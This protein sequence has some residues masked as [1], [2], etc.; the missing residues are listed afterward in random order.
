MWYQSTE[1]W[2]FFIGI[3][4]LVLNAIGLTI[5]DPSSPELYAVGVALMALLRA[6]K[7]STKLTFVK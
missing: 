3:I 2:V 6:T 5:V 1:L 4:N 7:T